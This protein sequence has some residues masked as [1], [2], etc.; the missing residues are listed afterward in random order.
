M[1]M[2]LNAYLDRINLP[3]TDRAALAP[4]VETLCTLHR[5]HLLAIA[6]E[7]LDI[8]LGAPLTLDV[9][10]IYRKIVD[11]GRGGW[12][13]EMN[14]LFAWVLREIGFDVTM[15]GA[16]VNRQR[17]D[18]PRDHLV[19]LVTGGDTGG[20]HFLADVGFGIGFLEPLPLSAGEYAQQGVCHRL[21]RERRAGDERWLFDN[22]WSNAPSFDFTLEPRAL[23]DF[24]EQCQHLQS[25]PE[26]GFVRVAVCHRLRVDGAVSLRGAVLSEVSAQGTTERTIETLVEYKRALR[27]TFGVRIER[28]DIERIDALW[29]KVWASHAAWVQTQE[30]RDG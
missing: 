8:H 9:A 17:A 15:L 19:L 1:T 27:E 30:S 7:N 10:Q 26:S 12:C 14:G 20:R 28:I 29:E 13:F 11:C 4:I 22:G 21:S 23:S 2:N 6:Y 25:S 5:A 3:H 24:A 18:D 16:T